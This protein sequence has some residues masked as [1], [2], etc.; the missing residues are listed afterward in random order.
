MEVCVNVCIL[1]GDSILM[2]E[3]NKPY[4]KGLLNIPGGH[5]EEGE[6]LLEGAMREVLEETGLKVNITGLVAVFNAIMQKKQAHLVN[7]M[8]I[9][10]V[11]EDT[12]SFHTDEIIG[13]D[14]YKISELNTPNNPRLRNVRL[15]EVFD[16]LQRGETY[17][18][19]VIKDFINKY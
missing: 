13:F 12:G 17:P 1:K 7:F 4:V 16:R 9:G 14:Y 2:V 11:V 10:E 8:F 6:N 18:L 5:L 3:E 15:H 19:S